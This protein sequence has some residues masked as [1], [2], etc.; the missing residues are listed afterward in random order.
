MYCLI[1]CSEM[2][3]PIALTTNATGTSPAN[4]SLILHFNVTKFELKSN[5]VKYNW[6]EIKEMISATF[7][8]TVN[9]WKF[10]RGRRM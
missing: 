6:I 4:S 9:Q 1:S 7:Y 3:E 2:L 8:F 5:R 10:G